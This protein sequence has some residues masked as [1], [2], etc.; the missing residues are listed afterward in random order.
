MVVMLVWVVFLLLGMALLSWLFRGVSSVLHP[1]PRDFALS[2]SEQIYE[3]LTSKEEAL[4]C[5]HLLVMRPNTHERM[6]LV[7]VVASLS[8][9]VAECRAESVRMVVAAWGLEEVAVGYILHHRG[10]HRLEMLEWLL[11]LRP[12]E[13]CVRRVVRRPFT[14]PQALLGQL[15]LV[16]Y[17]SP[18]RVVESLARHPYTLS[19][20]EVGRVVEVLKMHSPILPH[21][22]FEGTIST[23]AK[24][25]ALRLAAVEG[26]GDA[27]VLAHCLAQESEMVLRNAAMNVLLELSLFPS[28]EQSDVGC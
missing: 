3:L 27:E 2:L 1:L 4:G 20:E 22:S 5:S 9:S 25:L 15:L 7:G 12:S 17:A 23:N 18:E 13:E 16:V 19:W 14:T 10:R 21:Y 26:V 24:M 8:R 11:W 6:A 28:V